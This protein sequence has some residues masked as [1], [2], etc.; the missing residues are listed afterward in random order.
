MEVLRPQVTSH[1]ISSPQQ[2]SISFYYRDYVPATI[3]FGYELQQGASG[4]AT[5]KTTSKGSDYVVEMMKI[6]NVTG[7]LNSY[8][9]QSGIACPMGPC[10]CI[11]QADGCSK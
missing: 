11:G 5:G 2:I 7:M 4:H 8:R 3:G 6:V 1:L 9:P 10:R